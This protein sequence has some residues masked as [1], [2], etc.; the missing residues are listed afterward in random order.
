[1]VE[2]SGDG[3]G[4]ANPSIWNH[5]W[6]PLARLRWAIEAA[7]EHH[8]GAKRGAVLDFG[9]G[10]RP[11]EPLLRARGFGY[12]ACDLEGAPDVLVRPGDPLD[13]DDG[14]V[15]GVVSFQV[16][17]HV[18]DIDWYL[19]ECRRVLAADGWLLLS[20]HGA[21]L[22]HPHP[23]DYRRWTRDGLLKELDARGFE[24]VHVDALMGP[25]AWTTQFRALGL[26]HALLGVPGG[27]VL[28]APL[29]ML[30]NLRMVLEDAITPAAVASTNA[31]VYLVVCRVRRP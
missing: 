21:W 23:T 30:F 9:C 3:R 17:E 8:V 2:K 28:F 14:S 6:Y 29:M 24:P 19:G 13:V 15:Q 10:E 25:L 31:C 1:L 4:R 11:Y 12:V 26:R 16:L 22:Y 7:L 27:G 5:Q 18:W 20:T